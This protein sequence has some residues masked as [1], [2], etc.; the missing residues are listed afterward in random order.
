MSEAVIRAPESWSG[1]VPAQEDWTSPYWEVLRR[2]KMSIQRCVK[3][4]IW[5]HPPVIACPAC[6]SDDLAF[7]P[8]SGRG[9]VYSVTVCHREFGL[10]FGVPWVAAYVELEEGP[11]VATNLVNTTPAEVAIGQSVSVVYQDYDDLDLT[12]AFFEP[13]GGGR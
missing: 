8:V 5:H 7:E 6:G 9:T 11:R 3:C 1:P 10:R 12:L 2:H 4:R 13:S